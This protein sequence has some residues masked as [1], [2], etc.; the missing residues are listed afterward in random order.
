MYLFGF[1]NFELSSE[2]SEASSSSVVELYEFISNIPLDSFNI[3]VCI[4]HDPSP[5]SRFDSDL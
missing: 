5:P 2:M 3:L 1:V 4:Q